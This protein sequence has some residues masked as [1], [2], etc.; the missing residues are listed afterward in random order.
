MGLID[1]LEGAVVGLDTA[2]LIYLIEKHP[3]YLAA[4]KPFFIALDEGRL[5]AVTSTLTLTETLVH[6]LRNRETELV[7]QYQNILLGARNLTTYDLSPPI[8]VQ[9]AAIRAEY[10]MRTPDAIQLATALTANADFFLTN[11]R[12]LARYS[13]LEVLVVDK[14]ESTQ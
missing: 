1:D 10:K 2:P 12:E 4:V 5:T 9:A 11:D 7:E 6:P 13:E 3:R 14:L 8:A